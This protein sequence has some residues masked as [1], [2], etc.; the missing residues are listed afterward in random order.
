VEFLLAPDGSYYFL[1]MNTRIQ[2][3][4]PITEMTTGVDLVQEQIRIAMGQPISFKQD[5]IGQRGHSIEVRIYAEDPANKFLPQS[6][7]L[8]LVKE[9]TGPGVRVDSGIYSGS[10]VSTYY[11]PILSKLIVHAPNR[12][13]AIQRMIRALEDYTIL[14]IRTNIAFLIDVLSHPEF[15]KGHTY[16]NFIPKNMP[17]WPEGDGARVDSLS[18]YR[19]HASIAAALIDHLG[20]GRRAGGFVLRGDGEQAFPDAWDLVGSWEIASGR[21]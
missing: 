3:E 15:H 4:H 12:P 16:T 8:I 14:G 10:E 7:P 9:P 19:E 6:G 13:A 2:V 1:E 5:Q 20:L 18:Q 21:K 11:D 17:D